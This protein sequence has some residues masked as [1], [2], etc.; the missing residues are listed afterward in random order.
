MVNFKSIAITA[1]TF[2][3]SG[4]AIPFTER[5]VAGTPVKDTYIITLKSGSY[6][7][8]EH[9]HWVNSV[10]KRSVNKR[11][12]S[13]VSRTFANIDGFR[14]YTGEFD[15]ATIEEI[16]QN[17]DVGYPC[18]NILVLGDLMLTHSI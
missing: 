13:G 9:V 17:L 18:L 16:K 7:I 5:A 8:G 2:V 4:L 15:E 1:A 11:G 6:S 12:L 3:A 10:H 14:A